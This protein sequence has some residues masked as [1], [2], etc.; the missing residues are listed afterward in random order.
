MLELHNSKPPSFLPFGTI[1]SV[2]QHKSPKAKFEPRSITL[3]YMY[4]IDSNTIVT[5]NMENGLLKQVRLRN[6]H[7]LYPLLDPSLQFRINH[8]YQPKVNR[9][10]KWR[11]PPKFIDDAIPGPHSTPEVRRYPNA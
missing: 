6:F 3:R 8:G 2:P 10:I 9:I 7:P 5:M 4:P 11:T 1:G